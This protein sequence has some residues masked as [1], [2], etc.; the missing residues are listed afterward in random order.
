MKTGSKLWRCPTCSNE[1]DYDDSS[2]CCQRIRDAQKKEEK[3]RK[4]VARMVELFDADAA[5]AFMVGW[6]GAS[7]VRARVRAVNKLLGREAKIGRTM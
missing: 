1:Y 6:Y 4:V 3:F 5:G 2:E 7:T